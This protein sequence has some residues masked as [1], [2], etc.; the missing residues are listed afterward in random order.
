M[1]TI[2][3]IVLQIN[4]LLKPTLDLKKILSNLQISSEILQK[5]DISW[6]PYLLNCFMQFLRV[7]QIIAMT[8]LSFF[9]KNKMLNLLSVTSQAF[10]LYSLSTLRWIT[11]VQHLDWP[12]KKIIAAGGNL[13]SCTDQS[14]KNLTIHSVFLIP[15]S[16]SKKPL[17]LQSI[18]KS[19]YQYQEKFFDKSIWE[20]YWVPGYESWFGLKLKE[21]SWFRF[22]LDKSIEYGVKLKNNVLKSCVCTLPINLMQVI[23]GGLDMSSE[24]VLIVP[25]FHD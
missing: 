2:P 23:I 18:I 4:L 16:C 13:K 14:L 22:E 1:G 20:R 11:I 19:I 5:I 3:S 6:S 8:A 10:S 21:G 24:E 25:S 9:S 7:N 17:H 12:L 15:S